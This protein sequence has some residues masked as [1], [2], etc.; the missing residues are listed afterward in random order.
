M[1]K[2]FKEFIR[3]L[4]IG[5]S[6]SSLSLNVFAEYCSELEMEIKSVHDKQNGMKA[7]EN[8]PNSP[9][10]A[11]LKG[12]RDAQMAQVIALRSLKNIRD[13]YLK[14]K[15]ESQ[16]LDVAELFDDNTLEALFALE[17]HTQA[18]TKYAVIHST[19]AALAKKQADSIAQNSTEDNPFVK[20]FNHI[21]NGDGK[22]LYS[23]MR[24]ACDDA[25]EDVKQECSVFNDFTENFKLGDGHEE[26]AKNTINNYGQILKKIYAGVATQEDA[27]SF[28][29]EHLNALKTD[30]YNV[31]LDKAEDG[32]PSLS[33]SK[34]NNTLS[35]LSESDELKNYYQNTIVKLYDLNKEHNS[36]KNIF[37]S[38]ESSFATQFF[39][40]SIEDQSFNDISSALNELKKCKGK[41]VDCDESI[42]TGKLARAIN[43][44]NESIGSGNSVSNVT[45]FANGRRQETKNKLHDILKKGLAETEAYNKTTGTKT[46]FNGEVASKLSQLCPQSVSTTDRLIS[47]N[48][49]SDKV[50]KC[51]QDELDDSSLDELISKQEEELA[52]AEKAISDLFI[53]Q[54][55]KDLEII[56]SILTRSYKN[57]CE[58]P[59]IHEFRCVPPLQ[60]VNE[61]I[62][63]LSIIGDNLEEELI[64]EDY[65]R[66]Y[67]GAKDTNDYQ[68]SNRYLEKY[69]PQSDKINCNGNEVRNGDVTDPD[70]FPKACQYLQVRSCNQQSLSLSKDSFKLDDNEYVD[71]DP[72]S[73]RSVVRR[74]QQS[75]WPGVAMYAAE[76]S[77]KFMGPMIATQQLRAQLPSAI[78][79]GMYQEQQIAYREQYYDWYMEKLDLS[80]A[81]MFGFWGGPFYSNNSVGQIDFGYGW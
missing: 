76:Q 64:V 57:I 12:A 81:N 47:N 65:S 80:D 44:A 16:S 69:C 77:Y 32:S 31:S 63:T 11:D 36:D 74:H 27:T 67:Y 19:V 13:E 5:T 60:G 28:F 26:M 20:I 23:Y 17:E 55:M 14:F 52:K 48:E 39:T 71:W 56:K 6:L 59:Q 79:T 46:D 35:L 2:P 45:I 10:L 30:Q 73:E 43:S 72:I 53:S 70:E 51:L 18:V 24:S 22:N 9:T 29:K 34:P 33:I 66:Y 3:A 40:N 1:R 15:E 61:S 78:Y 37:S 25:S 62:K 8:K 38:P 50:F 58:D 42:D 54:P 41:L 7:D 49:I 75:F 4:I 21:K 68:T